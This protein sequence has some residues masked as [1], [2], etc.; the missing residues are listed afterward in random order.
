M[1]IEPKGGPNTYDS[2]AQP[3][4]EGFRTGSS[5]KNTRA[6]DASALLFD[7]DPVGRSASVEGRSCG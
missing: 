1:A 6:L 5:V 3:P 2:L 4:S 7:I